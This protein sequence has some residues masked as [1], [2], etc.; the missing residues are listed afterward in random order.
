MKTWEPWFHITDDVFVIG[1][2]ITAHSDKYVA[3]LCL[4]MFWC[5][6]TFYKTNLPT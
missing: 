1:F 6:I 2:M 4:G 5:G 3:S